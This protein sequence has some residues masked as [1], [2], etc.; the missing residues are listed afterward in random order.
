MVGTKIC[1]SPSSAA[2]NTPCICSGSC[3]SSP[4]RQI[5][6]CVSTTTTSLAIHI[7][8]PDLLRLFDLLIGDADVLEDSA[9]RLEG[10]ASLRRSQLT[11]QLRELCFH[12]LD[13][14]QDHVVAGCHGFNPLFSP[15]AGGGRGSAVLR[16]AG[17][18]SLLP[19]P[20]Y[21]PTCR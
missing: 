11:L 13:P 2:S 14:L 15:L 18:R 9:R 3:D 19:G 5:N 10:L 21:G 1:D 20:S 12:T 16:G 4:N 17:G 6:A 7:L 8:R